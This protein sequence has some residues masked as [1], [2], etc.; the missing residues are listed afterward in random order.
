[1]SCRVCVI[2]LGGSGNKV[3]ERMSGIAQDGLSVVA[4]NTDARALEETTASMKMQIAPSLTNG[5]GAG[6][7]SD[8]GRKAAQ[9]D[10]V[11]ITALC[12]DASL[13]VL[14]VGLGGGTGTGGAPVILDAAR[15]AGAM[16]LCFATLPFGFE[17]AQRKAQADR[18][19]PLL[20]KVAD[21]LI[22]I[23]NDRLS[24]FVGETEV[25]ESFD[26][27]N[28][29]LAKGVSSIAK[30]LIQPGFINLDFS[31]LCKVVRSSG[32]ICTFGYGQ[33]QGANR[34]QDALSELL[35][36]P[37]VD[38]GEVLSSARS[39]LVS[40]VGG[41]DLTL[42]DISSV[43]ES[44]TASVSSSCNVSMGTVV[45]SAWKGKL[46]VTVVTSEKWISGDTEEESA[47]VVLATVEA[48]DV[49][50]AFD[51]R[52]DTR[53]QAASTAKST[54][55]KKAERMQ[56]KLTIKQA[57]MDR[58]K[59]ASPSILDGEDGDIPTYIRRGIRLE[60]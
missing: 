17:G 13:V 20:N 53:K 15:Q 41:D 56:E 6:G 37:L 32:G 50:E 51:D 7:D 47:D 46:G 58:F 29:V 39:L 22:M 43:M 1:M 12:M 3:V 54:R 59:G 21:A 27:V 48:E 19:V 44:V 38:G 24:E 18:A 55:K 26:K 16:T 4:I 34:A 49:H 36:G 10:I 60:K 23:P 30:M 2:G 11:K 35:N 40:I 57:G 52:I 9:E 5:L 28:Q 31:D 33:G 42:K 14:V 45:D 25:S 8:V